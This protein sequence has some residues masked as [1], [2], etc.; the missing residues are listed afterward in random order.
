MLGSRKMG[1]EQ[2]GWPKGKSR[3]V[4]YITSTLRLRAAPRAVGLTGPLR[5]SPERVA[6]F[7]A[8]AHQAAW[9]KAI[10]QTDA[11]C[12]GPRVTTDSHAGSYGPEPNKPCCFSMEQLAVGNSERYWAIAKGRH[13]VP[14]IRG[15]ETD[16]VSCPS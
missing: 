13:W 14:G 16:C 2:P 1:E 9:G 6:S 7:T 5:R 11:V 10:P 8:E 12:W 3:M 4:T 15:V